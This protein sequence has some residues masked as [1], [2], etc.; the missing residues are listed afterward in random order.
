MCFFPLKSFNLNHPNDLFISEMNL[1]RLVQYKLEYHGIYSLSELQKFVLG[2]K[3]HYMV[4]SDPN[5][6]CRFNEELNEYYNTLKDR[7]AILLNLDKEQRKYLQRILDT[8]KDSR[9]SGN[10]SILNIIRTHR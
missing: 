10:R 2:E 9:S 7:E 1:N 3:R 5:E 4:S 6:Q 8:Y